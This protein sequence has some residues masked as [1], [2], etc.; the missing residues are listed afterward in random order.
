MGAASRTLAGER[1]IRCPKCNEEELRAYFHE[2]DPQR[3]RGTIWVWCPRCRVTAH[4]PRVTPKADLGP[5]PFRGLSL[6]QFAAVEADTNEPFMDKLDRLWNERKI[7]TN[8]S[9]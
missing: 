3:R 8:A 5:D 2:F 9:K 6:E 4:L 1:G 7:G